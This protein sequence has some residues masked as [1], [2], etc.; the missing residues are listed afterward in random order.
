VDKKAWKILQI[1]MNKKKP[2]N[3]WEFWNCSKKEGGQCPAYISDSGRECW[4]VAG[5]TVTELKKCLRLTTKKFKT[6]FEC[7]WYKKMN[8][9]SDK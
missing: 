4:M 8:P 3:C 7:H 9:G 2:Q 1:N 5:H 6:C